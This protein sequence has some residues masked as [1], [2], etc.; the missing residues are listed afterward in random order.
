MLNPKLYEFLRRKDPSIQVQDPGTTGDYS[1]E[2]VEKTLSGGR[3]VKR[4]R[5][6][7]AQGGH[8]GETY[9][10]N[11]I[12]CG[13]VKH[14]M[15]VSY[16]F[17]SRDQETK[18]RCYSGV[19]CFRRECH[20]DFSNLQ[21]LMDAYGLYE[22]SGVGSSLLG[23]TVDLSS[24]PVDTSVLEYRDLPLPGVCHDFTDLGSQHAAW[25]YLKSR[26]L[27]PLKV[28]EYYGAKWISRGHRFSA[29]DGRLFI[30]FYREGRLLGY[31]ARHLPGVSQD[32]DRKYLNSRGSLS[33][34][35][36][37]LNGAAKYPVI[38]IVEGPMDKWAVGEASVAV[39]NKSLG[40]EK[41]QRLT[42]LLNRKTVELV[43][44]LVDPVQNERDKADGHP[45]QMDSMVKAIDS[46]G[47]TNVLPVWL[48]E[49]LDP[50]AMHGQYLAY[51]LE[52]YLGSRGYQR[53]GAV[54]AGSV[55]STSAAC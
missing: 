51:Y 33:G 53:L 19:H 29:M 10:L 42:A 12:F 9:S 45:H 13:D 5:Y 30:P 47:M 26:G 17:G 25:S 49:W 16:L 18:Q 32:S 50:G 54:L 15:R 37:G 31:T 20:R 43:V 2:V 39:L 35:L 4:V 41:K 22:S 34:Y 46:L 52:N 48:P 40:Y 21:D 3:V 55:R 7:R 28:Q 27:D 6:Q 38:A 44:V 23:T 36:Y 8:F 24:N 1:R 11:C 14:R